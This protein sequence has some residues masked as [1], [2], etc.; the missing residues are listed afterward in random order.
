MGGMHQGFGDDLVRFVSFLV[1]RLNTICKIFK[2]MSSEGGPMSFLEAP[3][4]TMEAVYGTVVQAEGSP[5]RT[6]EECGLYQG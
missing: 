4:R 2:H 6:R 5:T 3:R 1:E